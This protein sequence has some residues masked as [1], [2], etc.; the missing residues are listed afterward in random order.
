MDQYAVFGNPIGHSKSPL[1]HQLFA[2]QTA[3]QMEYKAIEPNIEGFSESLRGF[4]KDGGKGANVT[5]PFKL[6]AFNYVDERS[7]RATLAGSVNT[8]KYQTNG[9]I[10]GD[11]TDGQGL[12][13]DLNRQF[14]SLSG[15][16]I[17]LLGAGGAAR[18]VIGPLFDAG[19]ENICILNRTES[20]AADLAQRFSSLGN[21][22]G[23]GFD[24]LA[25]QHVDLLINSTSSSMSADVPDMTLDKLLHLSF[26][27][28]MFY[29][30]Q[31]T[32]FM[33]WVQLTHPDTRV[34]DGLG[35]LVGQAAESFYLWRGVKPNISPVILELRNLL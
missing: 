15:L 23:L 18:G 30:R 9:I 34:S 14:G 10:L 22:N 3:Q 20:K 27:Y 25:A 11:N 19:V 29:Q 6:E 35:M 32:S 4:F 21:I 13:E 2:R 31:P 28:D 7:D 26:A 12:V 5:A 1:I 24:K 8:L 33:Q 17:M 16:R